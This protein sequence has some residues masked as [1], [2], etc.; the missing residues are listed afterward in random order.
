MPYSPWTRQLLDAPPFFCL[1]S[2]GRGCCC[3]FI[4][5]H[6][7]PKKAAMDAHVSGSVL[8]AP[9]KLLLRPW[10]VVGLTGQCTPYIVGR[11]WS[12]LDVRCLPLCWTFVGVLLCWTFV[13]EVCGRAGRACYPRE[14]KSGRS[15]W[16]TTAS[17]HH[18]ATIHLPNHHLKLENPKNSESP[19]AKW[20]PLSK[21]FNP[22]TTAPEPWQFLPRRIIHLHRAFLPL[23]PSCYHFG[24]QSRFSLSRH[25]SSP[26][27]I[28]GSNPQQSETLIGEGRGQPRVK[29]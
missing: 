27:P 20:P 25:C 13:L 23:P 4:F 15:S 5:L 22:A 12:V 26:P 29:P 6:A 18:R 7:P 14:A 9:P 8:D 10:A 11:V 17:H 21:P 28:H 2:P 3:A 19:F 24:T 16:I 1:L